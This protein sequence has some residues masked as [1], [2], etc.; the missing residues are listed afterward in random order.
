MSRIAFTARAGTVALILTLGIG[1]AASPAA[2]QQVT[3]QGA[4]HGQNWNMGQDLA[5][6]NAMNR[7]GSPLARDRAA[8][9]ARQAQF[10]RGFTGMPLP[11]TSTQAR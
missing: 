3:S 2:A 7:P 8:R 10:N 11:S 6:L 4:I 1:F 5:S 9:A